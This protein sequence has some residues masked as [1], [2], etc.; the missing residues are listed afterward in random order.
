MVWFNEKLDKWLQLRRTVMKVA[1]VAMTTDVNNNHV[2]DN[3][4]ELDQQQEERAGAADAI[5]DS[6]DAVTATSPRG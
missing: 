1:P 3:R 5:I 6:R 4:V 2:T